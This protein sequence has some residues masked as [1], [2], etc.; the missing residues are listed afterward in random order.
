[1]LLIGFL[2]GGFGFLD[3]LPSFGISYY[4]LGFLFIVSAA[5]ITTYV[6]W[7]CHFIDIDPSSSAETIINTMNDALL[8]IDK[9]RIIR[10][11]N[12]AACTLFGIPDDKIVNAPLSET[13]GD[14]PFTHALNL[15]EINEYS[16]SYELNYTSPQGIS[17]ELKLHVSPMYDYHR[18]HI[19]DVLVLQDITERK[20]GEIKREEL[21]KELQKALSEIKTLR[22]ILPICASCKKIRDDDGYWNQI[23]SYI[24][25]HSE[26]EFSHSICPE[27]YKK[28]YHGLDDSEEENK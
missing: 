10:I 11:A 21:I 7:R 18:Y 24:R 14:I 15:S 20:L 22:G 28:L 16:D 27:C 8:V 6:A 1:M 5:L 4:P 9:D 26:A 13:L 23:E 19:A 3:F 12:P 25:D 17:Y 2:I